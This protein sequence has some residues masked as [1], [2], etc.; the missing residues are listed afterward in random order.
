MVRLAIPL[1]LS[2]VVSTV[3][4]FIEYS[5]VPGYFMQDDNSTNATTFDYVSSS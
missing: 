1:L 3:S 5:V 2:G 4:A